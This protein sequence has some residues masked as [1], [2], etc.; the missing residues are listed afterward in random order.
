[1][2]E[3]DVSGIDWAHFE[4][5]RS[6]LGSSFVRLLGYF[7]EDGEK[8]IAAIEDAVRRSQA[9]PMVL[10]AHKLK[11]EA[12][13]FGAFELATLA[14][15]IELSARNCV[16]WRTDPTELVEHVVKLRPLFKS[17]MAD[18]D[19]ASNP[20]MQRRPGAGSLRF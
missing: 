10:P 12:R 11:S 5:T 20:L 17:T 14:E 8:S 16:E 7:H 6:E 4:R 19:E 3:E 1:M 13:E 9:A 2:S 18:L 15:H